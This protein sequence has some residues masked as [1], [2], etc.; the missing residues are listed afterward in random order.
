[1]LFI[2][3]TENIKDLKNKFNSIFEDVMEHTPFGHKGEMLLKPKMNL[4]EDKNFYYLDAELPGVGKSDIELSYENEILAIKARKKATIDE[5]DKSV[6]RM[7]SYHGMF[8]RFVALPHVKDGGIEAELKDGIL[9]VKLEKDINILTA[10][11][12][13]VK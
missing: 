10:K 2:K 13:T 9:K 8:E 1:M 7:E 5:K 12:I 4:H 11:K 6:H 3:N